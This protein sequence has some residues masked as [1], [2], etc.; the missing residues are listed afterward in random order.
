[1]KAL[2]FPWFLWWLASPPISPP[3]R[4][5]SVQWRVLISPI[6]RHFASASSLPLDHSTLTPHHDF[7]SPFPQWCWR[8]LCI[9]SSEECTWLPMGA[10]RGPWLVCKLQIWARVLTEERPGKGWVHSCTSELNMH[11]KLIN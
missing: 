4:F 6:L 11:G 9:H 5:S 2:P 1:M 8:C 3:T 10:Q 7:S